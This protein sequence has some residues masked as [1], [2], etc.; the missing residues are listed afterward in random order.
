MATQSGA[1]AAVIGSPVRHSKSP[2][3][4]NAAFAA[5]GLDW[6]FV[7][8]EVPEGRAIAALSAM[9]SFNLAGLSVTMPHKTAVAQALDHLSPEAEQLNAVN[10]VAR[11]S[12]GQLIGHNTDG[13]GL[14]ASLRTDAGFDPQGSACLVVGAGGAARA[15]VLALAQAGADQVGVLNRTEAKAR[16]AAELAGEVGQPV[17]PAKLP[18]ALP[19]YDL[20]INATPVGM[21]GVA[22]ELPFDPAE[23]S[24]SQLVVDLIYE[25]RETPLL[26]AVRAQGNPA[27]NGLGMLAHQA[28]VAFELWTQLEPPIEAMLVAVQPAADPEP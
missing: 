27:H 15:A 22:G 24:G 7:A 1:L 8:W 16:T 21:A 3:I 17:A 14:L 6:L 10:C 28:G 20:V 23:L 18:A 26:Q 4:H 13:A 11:Q 5:T 25:P 12:N 9:Q 2:A 19:S